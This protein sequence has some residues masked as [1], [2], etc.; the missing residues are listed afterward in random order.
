[1]LSENP[2]DRPTPSILYRILHP[3]EKDI[4]ALKTFSPD[5][6]TVKRSLE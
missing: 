3:F 5:K 4:L 1:M 2:E 6:E